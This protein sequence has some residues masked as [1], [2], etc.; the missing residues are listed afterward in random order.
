MSPA[1]FHLIFPTFFYS[2]CAFS[3][4]TDSTVKKFNCLTCWQLRT[5]GIKNLQKGIHHCESW[6]LFSIDFSIMLKRRKKLLFKSPDT[7]QQRCQ[8]AFTWKR[9][10]CI[11]CHSTRTSEWWYERKSNHMIF[12]ICYFSGK[13]STAEALNNTS[14]SKDHLFCAW[15]NFFHV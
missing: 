13:N 9:A 4:F 8:F 10:L 12:N 6:L 5:I 2:N 14:N 11:G 3:L 1:N 7:R 15:N